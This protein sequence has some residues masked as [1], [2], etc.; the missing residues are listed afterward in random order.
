M[1]RTLIVDDDSLTLELHRDYVA[2]LEGFEVAGTDGDVVARHGNA[3]ALILPRSSLK[4]LQAIA[5]ITAGAVL[6]GEQLA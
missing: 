1:I 4:P 5:C 6:E 2:R 3:D